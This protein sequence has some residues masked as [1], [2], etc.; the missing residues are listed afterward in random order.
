V[1]TTAHSGIAVGDLVQVVRPPYCPQGEHVHGLGHLFRVEAIDISPRHQ[2]GYCWSRHGGN[3]PVAHDTTGVFMKSAWW[4]LRRLRRIPPLEELDPAEG[5]MGI[6]KPR[7][8]PCLSCFL[9]S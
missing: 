7:F 8:V 3:F 1:E 9:D 2:C 6:K 4:D 5:R